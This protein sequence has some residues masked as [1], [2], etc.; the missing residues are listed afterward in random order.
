MNRTIGSHTVGTVH[1]VLGLDMSRKTCR[2]S[3][4]DAAPS[5]A[6]SPLATAVTAGPSPTGLPSII[7]TFL[8]N[9]SAERLRELTD[10]G[11]CLHSHLCGRSGGRVAGVRALWPPPS[12]PAGL[13]PSLEALRASAAGLACSRTRTTCRP[14][15][16]QAAHNT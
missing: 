9:Q 3:L 7:N 4:T 13:P 5:A 10:G 14:E 11:F 1:T 15:I 12:Q 6:T 2:R 16:T 8:S